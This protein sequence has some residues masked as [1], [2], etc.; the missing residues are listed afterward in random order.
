MAPHGAST[1]VV[2]VRLPLLCGLD[3]CGNATALARK[4]L[5]FFLPLRWAVRGCDL[6]RRHFVLD[7]SV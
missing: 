2:G 6:D 1:K 7:M 5:V 4:L 3:G